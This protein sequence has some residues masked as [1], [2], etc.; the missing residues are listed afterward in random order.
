MSAMQNAR[1][2]MPSDR[3][4]PFCGQMLSPIGPLGDDGT[5][6]VIRVEG[7]RRIPFTGPESHAR[8]DLHRRALHQTS[9]LARRA[10]TTARVPMGDTGAARL[11]VIMRTSGHHP[12]ARDTERRT[13]S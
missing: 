10:P 2:R 8:S 6:D 3:L 1:A 5:N 11:F 12:P 13:T 4:T 7:A 9:P